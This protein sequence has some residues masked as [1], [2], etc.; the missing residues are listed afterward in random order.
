MSFVCYKTPTL[1]SP[2]TALVRHVTL[3]MTAIDSH[4]ELDLSHGAASS[5]KR[6]LQHLLHSADY[7]PTSLSLKNEQDEQRLMT[8]AGNLSQK[9]GFRC[10][11]SPSCIP[12][13]PQACSCAIAAARM[14]VTVPISMQPPVQSQ[15]MLVGGTPCHSIQIR[16]S[17]TRHS[18]HSGE[19]CRLN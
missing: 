13:L 1:L 7:Q 3:G 10:V 8:T 6:L 17:R 2:F 16:A 18:N 15:E 9:G 12:P 19:E 14:A 11:V 4:C 5:V